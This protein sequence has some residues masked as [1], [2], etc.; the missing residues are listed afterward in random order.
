MNINLVVTFKALTGQTATLTFTGDMGYVPGVGQDLRSPNGVQY[1]PVKKV[2]HIIGQAILTVE[3]DAPM[4]DTLA[5][6]NALADAMTT[7][8]TGVGGLTFVGRT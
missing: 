5:N 2:S 1:M 6:A 8:L 3:A 7:A 4:R